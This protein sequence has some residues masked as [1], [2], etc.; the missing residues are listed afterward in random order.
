MSTQIIL[1]QIKVPNTASV[2][3]VVT[4][5]ADGTF[6]VSE[7][8]TSTSTST[9][10]VAEGSNLYYTNARVRSA[11]SGGTGVNYNSDTG[12]I[13]IGQNVASTA[14]VTF[15]NVS[16]TNNLTIYG[17]VTTYGANNISVSDNMIYLNSNSTVS[18]PDIGFAFNYNDGVYRHGGFFR[19][20]S[21]GTFKVFD[22]YSPEPDA[23]I[24]IDTAHASFR[25][26]N[27]QATTFF[28]NVTGTAGTLSNFT[29]AN[30]AEG[31]NLYYNNARVYSNVIALLPSLAGSG[32]LIQA[33]GQI[34]ATA[35]GGGGG[36]IANNT[37]VT[38]L[39][40]TTTISATAPTTTYNYDV[41][42]QS[43]LYVTAN[44]VRNWT[45]NVRGSAATTLNATLNV[46]SAITIAHAQAANSVTFYQ[47][48]FTI[49]GTSV[50]P[51]WATGTA[52]TN[53]TGTGIDMYVY[54][55]IKTASAT[56]TVLASR[57]NYT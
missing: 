30:L 9:S 38:A 19:D 48:A 28:G 18:N 26:A 2:G 22:N 12:G 33:N 29:T 54:T 53:S 35:T 15:H 23:N 43:V 40:E 1:S 45:L 47:S 57:T 51:K 13:S 32:V 10:N 34:N 36:S 44:A 20:A 16:I 4:V 41:S 52:P 37:V 17:G 56:Y 3:Q 25:L 5:Q 49:D 24:F 55:I 6:N 50:T 46:G 39:I 8:T 11:L 14:N 42:T 31:V 21:D 27:I 7:A